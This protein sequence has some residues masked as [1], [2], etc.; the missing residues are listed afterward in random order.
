MFLT[1]QLQ[2]KIGKRN[3]MRK[4]VNYLKRLKNALNFKTKIPNKSN[5]F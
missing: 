4:L 2:N 5:S 1:I 3:T